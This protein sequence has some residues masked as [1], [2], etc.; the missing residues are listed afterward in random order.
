MAAPDHSFA[1]QDIKDAITTG[2][3]ARAWRQLTDLYALFIFRYCHGMLGGDA[4]LAE[5]L[6][7]QVLMAAGEGLPKFRA[8]SSVK[9]WVLGIAHN[10][11]RQE[12]GVR[13]RRQT[14]M[15]RYRD[16][17]DAIH[18]G[19][20]GVAT[21]GGYAALDDH[22]LSH[23][24]QTQLKHALATLEPRAR[25]IVLL[26]FGIGSRQAE[27]SV[28]EIAEILGLSRSDAYRRLNLALAQ[29]KK[30]LDDELA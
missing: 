10:M 25:S 12:I 26:R 13:Q 2:E 29:L 24:Q 15:S 22:L 4:A 11:V 7:H 23:E 17:A 14:V 20:V 9:T 30:A 8:R 16:V 5:D 6:T 1:D 27:L 21:D 3:Y 19:H 28:P 18:P